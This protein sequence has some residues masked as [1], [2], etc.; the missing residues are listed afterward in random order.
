MLQN[1][2]SQYHF[3]AKCSTIDCFMIV[4]CGSK[5]SFQSA[6]QAPQFF[7]WR[8]AMTQEPKTLF[9]NSVP[10]YS[11][12][13]N[14]LSLAIDPQKC[15]TLLSHS[16]CSAPQQLW[17]RRTLT[18]GLTQVVLWKTADDRAGRLCGKSN[19]SSRSNI[20]RST[21]TTALVKVCSRSTTTTPLV[22][23]SSRSRNISAANTTSGLVDCQ[24]WSAQIKR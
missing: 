21:T 16:Q 13:I 18:R 17:W 11:F 20:S 6:P 12:T 24:W 22:K 8:R 15:S 10:K 1:I 23:V 2:A 3:Q 14:I 5:Y 19:S 9:N 4:L 7:W